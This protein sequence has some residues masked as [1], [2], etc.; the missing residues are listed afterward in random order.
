MVTRSLVPLNGKPM[1]DSYCL[2]P[3]FARQGAEAGRE[4]PDMPPFV[5]GR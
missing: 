5:P 1:L 2:W 4:I 3:S